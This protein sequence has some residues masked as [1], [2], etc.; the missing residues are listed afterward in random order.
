MSKSWIKKSCAAAVIAVTLSLASAAPAEARPLWE[1][2][3]VE[4]VRDL[5]QT[6]LAFAQSL[7]SRLSDLVANAGASLIGDG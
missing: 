2:S 5:A 1:E 3:V 6:P 7:W 4:T